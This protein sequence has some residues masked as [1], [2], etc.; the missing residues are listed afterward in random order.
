MD[1]NSAFP[2]VNDILHRYSKIRLI[3]TSN[4]KFFTTTAILLSLTPFL[5]SGD[6]RGLRASGKP[7][8]SE[9]LQ[10]S[11]ELQE[12]AIW[13]FLSLSG[14]DSMVAPEVPSAQP[15]YAPSFHGISYPPSDGSST[16]V[17]RCPD[18]HTEVLETL[19]YVFGE[20]NC[21]DALNTTDSQIDCFVEIPGFYEAS[22]QYTY[23]SALQPTYLEVT[24]TYTY[25]GGSSLL[26]YTDF[27]HDCLDSM[28]S[29]LRSIKNNLENPEP[30]VASLSP[31]EGPV[32]ASTTAPTSAPTAAAT[33]DPTESPISFEIIEIDNSEVIFKDI[34]NIFSYTTFCQ[35]GEYTSVE[36][37]GAID[38]K[39]YC[40]TNSEG[41]GVEFGYEQDFPDR[42]IIKLNI[43][44]PTEAECE[45][46][47]DEGGDNF[48]GFS[49][50]S[51]VNL[52]SGTV[53][54]FD[55]DDEVE[56]SI[57]GTASYTTYCKE[58][59]YTDVEIVGFDGTVECVT[60]LP[61]ATTMNFYDPLTLDVV[62][63]LE[64]EA[65]SCERSLGSRE[66][67]S[68][69]PCGFGGLAT[70]EYVQFL[71]F[72]SGNSTDIDDGNTT[73]FSL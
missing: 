57:T 39:I 34:A 38:G 33:S 58:N 12:N 55:N 54:K 24:D 4:M 9:E 60:N 11:S 23:N 2:A 6:K 68:S 46:I 48:C 37:V 15:T 47:E 29:Q 67:T 45:A 72:D 8:R 42:P 7:I 21:D 61:G 41:A 22:A 10:R 62:V 17:P 65:T 32:A 1:H 63:A 19:F 44:S 53:N 59:D 3:S 18:T 5:V 26:Q 20:V 43:E 51:S 16:G 70:T 66:I 13:D 36:V 64:L 25:V 14:L 69:F 28:Q 31:S 50:K 71:E 73:T 35:A 49:G 56:I 52:M 40:I 27:V 30:P